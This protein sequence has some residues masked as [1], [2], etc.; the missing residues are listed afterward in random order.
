MVKITVAVVKQ[1]GL[2]MSQLRGPAL[3]SCDLLVISA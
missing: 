2:S 1:Y 3:F